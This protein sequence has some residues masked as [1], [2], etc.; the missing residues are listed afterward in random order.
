ML[1]L[2]KKQKNMILFLTVYTLCHSGLWP[3]CY[4]LTLTAVHVHSPVI[5]M[6]L[7]FCMFKKAS[8]GGLEPTCFGLEGQCS[9]TE[10]AGLML[11]E[12]CGAYMNTW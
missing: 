3:Q 4:I 5:C 2:Q 1:P 8:L 12:V 6:D 7:V 9:T 11:I 10:L